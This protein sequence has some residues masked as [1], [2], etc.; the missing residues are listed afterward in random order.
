MQLS[1]HIQERAG[2]NTANTTGPVR[3]SYLQW[4]KRRRGGDAETRG[5]RFFFVIFD[6]GD[7][8]D[9]DAP[10]VMEREKDRERE[11]VG[12]RE[13]G[14]VSMNSLFLFFYFLVLSIV[15]HSPC[16]VITCA[17]DDGTLQRLCKTECVCFFGSMSG[18]IADDEQTR[19]HDVADWGDDEEARPR[20]PR[21][22]S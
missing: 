22:K 21:E 12:G 13:G 9:D 8:D 20:G 7:D 17:L 4:Q 14:A 6:D 19:S 10:G 3:R 15:G 5:V 11:R 1:E 16:D 2:A 18:K